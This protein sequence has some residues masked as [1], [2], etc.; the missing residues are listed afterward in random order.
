MRKVAVRFYLFFVCHFA[1][2]YGIMISLG[3]SDGPVWMMRLLVALL[4]FG[5]GMVLGLLFRMS[6]LDMET[7]ILW[8][9]VLL[10]GFAIT[11]PIFW[12]IHI[13]K[14]TVSP[15]IRDQGSQPYG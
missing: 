10:F 5:V 13:C 6:S 7:K 14:L 11:F 4:F 2:V 3:L 8:V 12:W 15:N 1:L 9:V